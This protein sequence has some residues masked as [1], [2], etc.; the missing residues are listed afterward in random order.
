MEDTYCF[1][2]RSEQVALP[3]GNRL[4]PHHAKPSV[5]QFVR[6]DH[7]IDRLQQARSEAGM[8]AVGRVHDLRRHFVFGPVT[9]KNNL[10]PRRQDAR[11][12]SLPEPGDNGGGLRSSK[13]P[14]IQFRHGTAK[15]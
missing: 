9:S 5:L 8:N 13:E 11:K 7:F 6:Q 2:I 14:E 10:M 15:R 4:L 3:H 1:G 12:T